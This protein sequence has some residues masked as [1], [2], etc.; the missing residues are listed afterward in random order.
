M[1]VEEKA[2]QFE[3]EVTTELYKDSAKAVCQYQG[4]EKPFVLR[5][6]NADTRFRNFPTGA[7][8]DSPTSRI[9][10]PDES[11]GDMLEQFSGSFSEKH[12][13]PGFSTI[14]LCTPFSCRRIL[15]TWNTL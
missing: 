8:E 5:T 6:F 1:K 14:P 13:D 3:P 4:V 2:L 12:S 15:P 7:L 9:T 10:Q 11:F